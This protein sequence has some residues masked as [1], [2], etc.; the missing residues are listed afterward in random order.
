MKLVLVCRCCSCLQY[1]PH[2][3]CGSAF[4]GGALCRCQWVLPEQTQRHPQCRNLLRLGRFVYCLL[5]RSNERQI[6]IL[7]SEQPPDIPRPWIVV[8]PS[9]LFFV[10]IGSRWRTASRVSVS[11][12]KN[13]SEHELQRCCCSSGEF[14]LLYSGLSWLWYQLE[15]KVSLNFDADVIRSMSLQFHDG[16]HLNHRDVSTRPQSEKMDSFWGC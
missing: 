3:E 2:H 5:I 8:A 6:S 4:P 10:I 16:D 15:I 13:S 7:R 14:E 12:R 9:S 11:K 1:L